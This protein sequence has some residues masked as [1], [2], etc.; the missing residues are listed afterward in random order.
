MTGAFF[1]S[2]SDFD[3]EIPGA[4]TNNIAKKI[5][6]TFKFNHKPYKK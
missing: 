3:I 1:I 4:V 6:V 2:L 5:K